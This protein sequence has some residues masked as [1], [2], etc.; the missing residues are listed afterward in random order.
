MAH[1][2]IDGHGRSLKTITE[3]VTTQQMDDLRDT[4]TL[5]SRICGEGSAQFIYNFDAENLYKLLE[6]F[7]QFQGVRGI[8]VKDSSGA[9][10]AAAW[11][12]ESVMT[13]SKI[14]DGVASA[15]NNDLSFLAD[16]MV[17]GEKTGTVRLYYTDDFIRQAIEKQTQLS[18][19]ERVAFNEVA[20]NGI[21]MVKKLQIWVTVIILTSLVLTIVLCLRVIVIRPINKLIQNVVDLAD[22]EG[23]LTIRLDIQSKDEIG[24][25]AG[26]FN[27]FIQKLHEIIGKVKVDAETV[28][29]SSEE[30]SG[31]SKQMYS[32]SDSISTQTRTVAEGASQ[33]SENMG[34]VAAGCEQISSNVAVMATATEEMT[35]T[36]ADIALNCDKARAVTAEATQQA[37]ITSGKVDSLGASARDISQITGVITEIA[38]Q[39]NLLALNATIEAA[40]AGEA[41]KGFNVVANEI[42]ELAIQTSEATSEIKHKIDSIQDATTETVDEVSKITDVITS[43]NEI[44][45][46]IAAALDEQATTTKEISGNIEESAVSLSE[47][48]NKV[49]GSSEF[50]SEIAQNMN[51][52][53]L[54]AGEI[55]ESST[56][57]DQN[58]DKLS[59]LAASLDELMKSFK[60]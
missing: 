39:T 14:P 37:Q 59:R 2:L 32:G 34:S 45:E 40:R 36:V 10:F 30:F 9:P 56:L 8:E 21:Q 58:A 1:Q 20:R 53:T 50:S 49:A 5:L 35:I 3:K 41:G 18:E 29:A 26:R 15:L 52:L 46:V 7:M 44:V 11:L 25:L 51:Q 42:K 54:S 28:K 12:E 60:V 33:L 31:L 24:Q 16:A 55:V 47:I 57:V 23:D 43:V 38:A 17:N 6:S 48:N 13:G 27:V 22:G 19:K 4:T